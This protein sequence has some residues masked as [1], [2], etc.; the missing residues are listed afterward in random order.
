MFLVHTQV[1]VP[2]AKTIH[3]QTQ[4]PPATEVHAYG[5]SER[6]GAATSRTAGERRGEEEGGYGELGVR[7]STELWYMEPVRRHNSRKIK[8]RII[9]TR[10]YGALCY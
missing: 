9:K 2:D 1:F 3:S 8:K 6:W 5:S 7:R 10:T 4:N